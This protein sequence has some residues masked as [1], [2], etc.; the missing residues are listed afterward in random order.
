M[1]DIM[2]K[3]KPT[4]IEGTIFMN[5]RSQA[6]RLPKAFRLPGKRVRVSR[7]RNG[8]LLTPVIEDV[9]AWFAELDRL[10]GAEF[11][12]GGRNQPPMPPE[13]DLFD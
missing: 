2:N 3:G 1:I 13:K 7:E 5:G 11:F 6:V 10:A 12:E 9:D 4:S 8:I